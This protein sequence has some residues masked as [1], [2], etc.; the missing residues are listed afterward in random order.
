M[1]TNDSFVMDSEY[2]V[3]SAVVSNEKEVSPQ[4]IYTTV[5]RTVSNVSLVI[6]DI[7]FSNLFTSAEC[8]DWSEVNHIYYQIANILFLL[9]FM[10]PSR[11]LVS[12]FFRAFIVGA[13]SLHLMFGLKK[14]CSIDTVVWSLLFLII[15]TGWILVTLFRLRRTCLDKKLQ[16]V[17]SKL[18]KPL[19]LSKSQF[20]MIM[21]QSRSKRILLP[22]EKYIQEKI[23]RVDSLTLVLSGRFVV[24]QQ[25]T[26]LHCVSQNQFVD[27]PEWFGVS[28]DEYFQVTVTAVDKCEVLVWHRDK[29]KFFLQKHPFL[30]AVFDHVLGRDV[31]RKLIQVQVSSDENALIVQKKGRNRD[32]LSTLLGNPHRGEDKPKIKLGNI[33]ENEHESLV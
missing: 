2:E 16:P 17:Y 19:K 27:S 32:F 9:A 4:S 10:F 15:N 11:N 25:N 20:K 23:D 30:E 33:A 6:Q 8:T 3:S 18:F 5:M 28:T 26:Y 13:S 7:D 31:V 24:S 1:G 29:L 12:F 22:K 14:S 21:E